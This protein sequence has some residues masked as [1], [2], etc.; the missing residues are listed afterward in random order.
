VLERKVWIDTGQPLYPNL[1]VFLIAPSAKGKTRV[2]DY[3]TDIYRKVDGGYLAPTSITRASLIDVLAESK[4]K[5]PFKGLGGEYVEYNTLYIAIDEF[6]NLMPEYNAD[7][8]A[9]LTKFYDN[10]WFKE[11]K[12]AGHIRHDID[13]PNLSILTGSTPTNL[14]R[15]LKHDVWT[16]G[17]TGRVIMLHSNKE[18]RYNPLSLRVVD[19]EPGLEHDIQVINSYYGKMNWTDEYNET[20]EEW[21][22]CGDGPTHPLLKDYSARRYSHLYKLSMISSVD[23]GED[24]TLRIEDFE[25][26][27]GW[28]LEAEKDMQGI[29]EAGYT[30]PDRQAIDEI[31]AFLRK[32]GPQPWR[33]VVR[34]ASYCVQSY[35]LDKLLNLMI[36]TGEI[37]DVGGGRWGPS[38]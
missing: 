5:L 32:E 37:K 22:H 20:Q 12:R 26:A 13:K 19:K 34:K 21:L 30:T 38:T 36:E 10:N 9:A 29:F 15:V 25:K 14:M 27:K 6:S 3:V 2:I 23:R 17:L 28:L 4:R 11:A 33:L 18:T 1:Y 7:I 8:M 16:Q 35:A 24:Y 31:V